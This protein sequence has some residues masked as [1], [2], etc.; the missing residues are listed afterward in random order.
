MAHTVNTR[1]ETGIQ[2]D[3]AKRRNGEEREGIE[4]NDR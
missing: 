1:R 4:R 3:K 2:S